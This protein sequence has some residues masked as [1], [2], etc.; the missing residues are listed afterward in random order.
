MAFKKT[1][2]YIRLCGLGAIVLFT[3]PSCSQSPEEFT[4]PLNMEQFKPG[5]DRLSVM[6]VVGQP[7]STLA[8]AGRQCDTYQLYTKGLSMG[9]S[10]SGSTQAGSWQSSGPQ[11]QE[12][13]PL[14]PTLHKL[15][16][17]YAPNGLL[18]DIYDQNPTT[19][20]QPV[21]RVF[22]IVQN[23][24]PVAVSVTAEPATM[25]IDHVLV[26]PKTGQRIIYEKAAVPKASAQAGSITLDT[27]SREATNGAQ[28]VET[29]PVRVSNQVT[30]D[31]LNGLSSQKA[32]A[33][34]RATFSQALQV[35]W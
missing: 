6:R 9:V 13:A 26:D 23:G 30:T 34:N 20:L 1:S 22:S 31:E 7:E 21:H 16:F 15:V 4:A 10:G 11:L 14:Q 32:Q 17:C 35:P 5:A 27:V 18:S 25:Q 19:S 24:A 8:R 2:V 28:L 3:L 12:S 29:Q 33:A